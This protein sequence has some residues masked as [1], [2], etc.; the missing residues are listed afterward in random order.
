MDPVTD[1]F[2][3]TEE[4]KRSNPPTK[5]TSP[6]PDDRKEPWREFKTVTDDV[7]VSKHKP[8]VKGLSQS[9]VS[10][11]VGLEVCEFT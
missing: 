6:T 11:K 2:E 8:T 10:Q 5:K 3:H 4:E 7:S 9:L 1:S